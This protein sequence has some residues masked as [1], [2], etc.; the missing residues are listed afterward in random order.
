MPRVL[1]LLIVMSSLVACQRE[2]P[3]HSALRARLKQETRLTPDE[4]RTFFDQI[5]GAI[6][7]QKVTVREGALTRALDGQQRESVLGLLSDPG[8]VSD[9]GLRVEGGHTW[10]GIESDATPPLAELSATQTLWIDSDSFVPRRYELKYS[11]AGF[12]DYT[13]DLIFAP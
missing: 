10:R 4:I 13:Y 6:A 2:A 11:S 9:A 8:L 3:A 1:C 12:G 5:A 7:D